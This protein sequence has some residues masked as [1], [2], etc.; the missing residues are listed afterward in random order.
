MKPNPLLD[1]L[2]DELGFRRSV[3][4]LWTPPSDDD[5]R[6][7]AANIGAPL[8]LEYQA[9][10]RRY[11]GG[12]FGDDEF[13]MV[14][15]LQA[16]CPWGDTVRPEYFYALTKGLEGGLEYQWE[17]LKNRL[18]VGSLPIVSDAGGN[19]L[20][21]DVAG[22]APGSVWFWDHEQSEE[23]AAAPFP[24]GMCRVASTFEDF[25]RSMKK[26]PY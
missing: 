10:L 20:C 6:R 25:L 23:D 12:I 21:L 13:K 17:T 5:F 15:P 9:F 24:T 2:A 14:V 22:S 1:R 7:I 16:R 4:D 3:R 8:P 26:V 18:P 19:Q 11:G